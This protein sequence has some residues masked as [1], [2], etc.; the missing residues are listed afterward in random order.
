MRVWY[1]RTFSSV[2][3]AMTLIRQ[4]DGA[5]RYHLIYSAGSRTVAANAAHQF[6]IEPPLKGNE[7]L[8]WCLAFC[9]RWDIG[10]FVPH[11]EAALIGGARERFAAVGTRVLALG[12]PDVLALLHDKERFYATVDLPM[13]PPPETV[14]F[15]TGA[16]FDAGHA[17]LRA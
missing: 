14:P 12:G 16:Q 2:Y 15:Q 1:N 3:N 13:A 8:E 6:E 7:Y 4:H 9:Q 11:R 5:G 10:I 17:P